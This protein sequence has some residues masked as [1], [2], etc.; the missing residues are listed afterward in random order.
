MGKQTPGLPVP[1]PLVLHHPRGHSSSCSVRRAALSGQE[2]G[3]RGAQEPGPSPHP[4]LSSWPALTPV[5]PAADTG[6]RLQERAGGTRVTNRDELLQDQTSQHRCRS[7]TRRP[8]ALAPWP[9][10]AARDPRILA[11]DTFPPPRNLPPAETPL[12]HPQA[13]RGFS[14]GARAREPGIFAQGPRLGPRPPPAGRP[15]VT[16]RARRLTLVGRAPL[17]LVL[18]VLLAHGGAGPERGA[19]GCKQA[20]PQRGRRRRGPDS[21]PAW[22]RGGRLAPPEAGAGSRAV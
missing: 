14:L 6:P 19:E 13:S 11:Q 21:P 10:T 15:A 22:P 4:S 1:P 7:R 8:P 20:R 12:P 5:C 18:L 3:G 2:Q 16:K 17:G 9:G